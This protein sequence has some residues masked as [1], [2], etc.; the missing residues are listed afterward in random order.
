MLS[1]NSG[2]GF[3]DTIKEGLFIPV[4]HR[5]YCVVMKRAGLLE[6]DKTWVLNRG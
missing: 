6:L 5:R 2:L 1:Q 4:S 3:Q